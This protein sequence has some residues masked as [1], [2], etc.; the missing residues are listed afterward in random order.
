VVEFDGKLKCSKAGASARILPKH[1]D[2]IGGGTNEKDQVAMSTLFA[3]FEKG[4]DYYF[5]GHAFA[6]KLSIFIA[7]GLL[8][9]LPTIEFLSWRKAL[10]AG[11]APRVSAQRLR[12]VKKIV[13]GEMLAVALI[14]L[15]A[16]IMARGGL[17]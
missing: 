1:H 2:K 17:V 5:H 11:Q 10:R 8:S 3:F 6:A 16:A 9:I 12:V 15:F 4:P 14:L 7:A 13:H